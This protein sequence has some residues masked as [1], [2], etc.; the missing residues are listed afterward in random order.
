MGQLIVAIVNLQV[1]NIEQESQ[2]GTPRREGLVRGVRQADKAPEDGRA[3]TNPCFT[4]LLA[5]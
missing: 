2:A 1:Q 4:L 5:L 3:A